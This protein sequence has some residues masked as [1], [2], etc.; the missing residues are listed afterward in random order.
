MYSAIAA[1]WLLASRS[2]R[3]AVGAP[4]VSLS[5]LSI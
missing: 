5:E 2:N 3:S 1:L 4:T